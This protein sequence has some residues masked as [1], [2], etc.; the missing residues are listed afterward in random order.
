VKENKVTITKKTREEKIKVLEGWKNGR[1]G[2]RIRQIEKQ[3][4]MRKGKSCF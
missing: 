1:R 4:G 3:F 2:R